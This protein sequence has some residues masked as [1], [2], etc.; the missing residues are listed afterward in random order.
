LGKEWHGCV[1]KGGFN[2]NCWFSSKKWWLAMGFNYH[3]TWR[4]CANMAFVQK[5]GIA[6]FFGSL[7]KG[8]DDSPTDLGINTTSSKH[9]VFSWFL[10]EMNN[11]KKK[12]TSNTGRCQGK[13]QEVYSFLNLIILKKCALTLNIHTC[14]RDICQER[15]GHGFLAKSLATATGWLLTRK[16]VQKLHILW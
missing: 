5:W 16:P 2:L 9:P 7:S 4:Y 1:W 6:L 14:K 11:R 10:A 12:K 15:S 3:F 13:S 8:N